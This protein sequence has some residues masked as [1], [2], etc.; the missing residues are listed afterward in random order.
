M[1]QSPFISLRAVKQ[2]SCV[3]HICAGTSRFPC[4][5]PSKRGKGGR[6]TSSRLVNSRCLLRFR[7]NYIISHVITT[8]NYGRTLDSWVKCVW[9]RVLYMIVV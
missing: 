5:L 3:P 8:N 6:Q 9:T 7:V 4:E 1:D 2:L